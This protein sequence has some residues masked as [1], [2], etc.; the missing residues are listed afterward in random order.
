ML[1][2]LLVVLPIFALILSGFVARRIR[3]LGP[4]A[5]AEL[6]RFV[7][8]LAL[9]A[10]L[11]DVTAHAQWS[12]IWKPGF[13]ATFGLS[14]LAVFALAVLIRRRADHEGAEADPAVDVLVRRLQGVLV[15]RQ[16][17]LMDYDVR[18]ETV[19]KACAITPGLESP[20]VSPLHDREWVAI[21][22]TE[23]P[24]AWARLRSCTVARPGSIRTAIFAR[25][26]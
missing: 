18:V 5:T 24:T 15:A 3:L 7:V 2:T 19:E 4:G 22:A 11:F 14:S 16:Y 12:A 10:L 26:A 13:I 21:R 9:P 1:S 23:A 8:F 6:N 17:V 25:F 20:T